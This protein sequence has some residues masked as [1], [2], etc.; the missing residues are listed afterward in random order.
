M[1]LTYSILL[2]LPAALQVW[3]IATFR[4]KRLEKDFPFFYT[5][6]AIAVVGSFLRF[7][8]QPSYRIY[9]VTYWVTAAAYAIFSL[10]ATFEL[11]PRVFRT[12]SRVKQFW[13]VVWI[14]VLLM[15]ALAALHAVFKGTVQAGPVVATI[16]GLEIAV[17]YVQ[18]GVFLIMVAMSAFYWMPL[19]RYA[20]GIAFGF[21]LLAAGSLAATLLRSE[22]GTRFKLLVTY[23]PPV[24]YVIAVVI[25]LVTFSRPEPPDP[26]EQIRSPLSPE[27]VIERVKRLA[28]TLKGER[29]DINLLA[30]A[31]SPAAGTPESSSQAAARDSAPDDH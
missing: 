27:Q 13:I 5:Y 8:A 29:D 31:S 22:F 2:L 9:F 26:F 28:K 14:V 30:S 6:S 23:V 16:A 17:G 18:A 12:F 25:W 20:F 4:Q 3:L 21:G 15:I 10:L 19:R 7:V 1:T 24:V 11:F